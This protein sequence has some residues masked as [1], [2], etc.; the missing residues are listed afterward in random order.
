MRFSE[1]KGKIKDSAWGESSFSKTT[2]RTINKPKEEDRTATKYDPTKNET[3]TI[4]R[5]TRP[6]IDW[7]AEGNN[8]SA[9]KPLAEQR[10]NVQKQQRQEEKTQ[11]SEK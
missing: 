10:E 7:N 1:N 3:M 5:N 4:N 2:N 8:S 6:E 9:A 11:H